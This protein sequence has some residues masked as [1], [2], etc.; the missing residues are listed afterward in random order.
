M[1]KRAAFSYDANKDFGQFAVAV[2][3]VTEFLVAHHRQ[4][5][6]SWE[7]CV[8]GVAAALEYHGWKLPDE[9]SGLGAAF[10]IGWVA[11]EVL[12][13][14]DVALQTLRDMPPM[15]LPSVIREVIWV[16]LADVIVTECNDRGRV[17]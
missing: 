4:G 3:R 11:R 10:V 16:T 6:V 15:T 8:D 12:E 14:L 17:L 7:D 9:A 1:A 2:Y 5:S 13:G